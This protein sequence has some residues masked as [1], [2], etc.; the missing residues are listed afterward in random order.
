MSKVEI[1]SME[2]RA[3][4]GEEFVLTGRAVS[5]KQISTN[6]LVP[7]VRERIMPGAFR[8]SLASG[9]DVK[10]FL[11]HDAKAIPLG[12]LQNKTLTLSDSSEGLDMRVQLDKSISAHRDVYASVKRGDLSEMSFA[13][14]CDEDDFSDDSFNGQRC[15]VRNVRKAKLFDVS[16]VSSPFYGAGATDVAARTAAAAEVEGKKKW[17]ADHLADS[18]RRERAHEIG[19]QLLRDLKIAGID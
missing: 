4:E 3:A 10:A 13:F 17:L 15:Q 6:E 12:R 7:G 9:R 16:V 14:I 2:I 11:N 5:Y 1:R 8:E 19:M 18:A